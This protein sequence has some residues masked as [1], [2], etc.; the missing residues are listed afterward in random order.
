MRR[1][2]IERV[3]GP[4]AFLNEDELYHLLRVLRAREGTVFEGIDGEG[5]KH[6]CRL[7]RDS[8]TWYGQIFSSSVGIGESP[9]RITLG[10]ALIK[11]SKFEWVIQKSV[12][13]GVMEVIP[14]YTERTEVRLNEEREERKTGRWQRI[15][16]EAAKQSGRSLIPKLSSPV[17]LDALLAQQQGTSCLVM[18]E[19]GVSGLRESLR[20]LGEIR[21][22]L[23]LIGPEGGWGDRDRKL[24]SAHSVRSVS[25]GPRI[26]RT[27]T[28]S[29]VALT[30][31]QYELG[32]L[33]ID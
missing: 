6:H 24:F 15:L 25:L 29:V 2:L 32:D 20:E 7:C 31:L 4:R 28:A 16:N 27:E 22:C 11:K 3:E 10:Q 14:V 26:F 33:G 8:E 19:R 17:A 12:E 21:S 1:L 5:R 13:L 23:V 18:D 30:L 9:L